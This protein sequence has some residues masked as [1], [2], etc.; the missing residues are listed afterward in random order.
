M[1]E[2]GSN[3]L[4]ETYFRRR[5]ELVHYFTTRLRS[6]AAA[7]DLVQDL[8]L[9]VSAAAPADLERPAAFLYKMGTRLML[10]RL[11]GERRAGIRDHD[12]YLARSRRIGNAD[13]ADE[14][15]T[16]DVLAARQRLAQ[17]IA[18]VE[19]LPPRTRRAYELHKLQGLSQSATAKIMGVSSSAIEKLIA[20]ATR[21]L[22][23]KLR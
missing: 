9:K 16:E 8:Y 5:V 15:A 17:V 21:R 20:E 14:P 10:D 12:W 3:P 6:A 23:E 18:A 1:D 22:V 13:A 2:A 19:A 11:R 7:E 4:L